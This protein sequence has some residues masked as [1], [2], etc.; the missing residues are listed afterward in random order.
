MRRT[1]IQT[2]VVVILVACFACPVLEAF[3]RWDHTLQTGD[4]T[5]ARLVILALCMGV[6][7][8]LARAI[9]PLCWS[10]QASTIRS[11]SFRFV[12]TPLLPAAPNSQSQS[13]LVLR[14]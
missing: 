9:H 14:I 5:E 11:I 10:S 8:I 7:L 3:D 13:P 12:T 6:A 1:F 4:D 2:A